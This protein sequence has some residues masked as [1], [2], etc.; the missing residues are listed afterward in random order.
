[1][2]NIKAY[3]HQCY[4]AFFV[5]FSINHQLGE[6][7][8]LAIPLATAVRYVKLLVWIHCMS[9]KIVGGPM[10]PIIFA[11]AVKILEFI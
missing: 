1:M 4:E 11:F 3:K 5:I 8:C 2:C 6:Y 9:L 7:F 10:W